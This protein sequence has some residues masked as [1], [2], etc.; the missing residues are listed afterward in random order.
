MIL[1]D[2][3][4]VSFKETIKYCPHC[5]TTFGS[6]KLHK[7]VPEYSNFSFEIIEYIGRK[8]YKEYCTENE[9]LHALNERNVKIS[10]R[11]IS[12][13]G[14]KFVLYVAQGHKAIE[15]EI[16]GLLQ[17]SGGF[18]AHLDSTCEGASPHFFCAVEEL[19]KL[20]LLSRKIP[21]EST[22]AI[23]PILQELK[24]SYGTPLAIVCDMSKAIIAAVEAVFPGIRIFLCHFHFLRDLGKD[25]L[26]NDYDLLASILRD[27]DVKPTLSRFARELHDLI[28][29][30]SSLSC[31]LEKNVDD[32]FSQKLPEEVLSYLLIEWIQSY[33]TELAGYGFPFDR[34]HLAHVQ[35]MEI[36]YEYLQKLP[37]KATDRLIRVRD[38]LEELLSHPQLKECLKRVKKKVTHFDQLRDIMRLA[39]EDGKNGLNDDGEEVN[40][41][42]MK[43]ELEEFFSTD[44][45]KSA[46]LEDIGYK[47]MIS[48][49]EKYKDRLFTDGIDTIAA[50]GEKIHIQPERTNNLLERFFRGEKRGMRKRTGCKSL[51]RALKTMVAETPYVKNLGNPEY[52]KLILNG[53]TALAE[54]FAEID[55]EQVRKAMQ[56]HHEDQGRLN[57]CIKKAI[58][59][60]NLL[61]KIVDIYLNIGNAI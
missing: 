18:V 40:M 36:A 32:I 16:K 42:E 58:E 45:I 46:G 33:P 41:C 56:K 55:S 2:F 27:F 34:A 23:I 15:P 4:E 3:G 8:L 12:F 31:Y 6:E 14:K 50:D 30:Y 59:D 37:L 11:E 22:E 49:V 57:P 35:R 60:I 17:K 53:K 38:F 7:L 28:Q 1:L 51:S 39:P 61:Q 52:E 24:A 54:R 5:E 47:K 9:V 48:Q 25:L 10:P 19:L 44:E 26:K 43:N 29:K 13:L 21:S 20:V